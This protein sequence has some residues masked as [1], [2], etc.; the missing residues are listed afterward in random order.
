VTVAVES[1]RQDWAEGDRRFTERAVRQPDDDRLHRALELVLDGLRRRLGSFF[2]LEELADTY[3]DAERWIRA[4]FEEGLEPGWAADLTTV[5]D[6]AFH[7]YSRSAV[8]YA[9]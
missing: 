6:A 3:G 1:A 8:D 7:R 2:T 9:P 5:Q 4:S